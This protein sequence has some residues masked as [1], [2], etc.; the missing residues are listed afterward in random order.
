M[1][2]VDALEA[3]LNGDDNA[4]ETDDESEMEEED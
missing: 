3:K 1:E 2:R 4:D